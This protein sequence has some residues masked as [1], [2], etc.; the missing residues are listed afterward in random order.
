MKHW[1]VSAVATV[2]VAVAASLGIYAGQELEQNQEQQ[3][4]IEQTPPRTAGSSSL[5]SYLV[6]LQAEPVVRYRGSDPRFRG[7][8]PGRGRKLDPND[9]AV[10]SYASYLD[11][12]HDEVLRSAGGGRKLYDYQYAV[13]GFSAVLTPA[14]A[15]Q[16]AQTPGVAS[17]EPD[18]AAPLVTVTSPAFL[19][20]D[21][22]GGL[23]E[24]VGGVGAAGED[25]IIGMVDGGV[26]P[27][28]PSFSD[29]TGTNK[30]GVGGKLSYHQIPGWH[31]KCVPG[32]S[33]TPRTA[34]RS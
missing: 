25:V 18:A 10:R 9:A 29:R 26:W 6:R 23:W 14:Q 27:E 1:R 24:H 32:K 12:T 11:G 15:A 4:Q 16:L 5:R 2:A 19:G 20:L 30:N 17:V 3:D 31:G 7:T 13:N 22:P 34:I 8:A 21:A 28:H 33:S